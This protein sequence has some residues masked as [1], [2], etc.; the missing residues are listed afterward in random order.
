MVSSFCP[1]AEFKPDLSAFPFHQLVDFRPKS[2]DV[3]SIEI[4]KRFPKQ[5]AIDECLKSLSGKQIRPL[6]RIAMSALDLGS[7][8]LPELDKPDEV[9]A[10]VDKM[11][12]AVIRVSQYI[13]MPM[14]FIAASSL[15]SLPWA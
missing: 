14:W 4:F 12:T 10:H 7:A 6:C 2:T 15:L 9:K 1:S 13:L 8:D 5:Q 3:E 11:Q